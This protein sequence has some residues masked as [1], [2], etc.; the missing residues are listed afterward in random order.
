MMK[1]PFWMVIPS[2]AFETLAFMNGFIHIHPFIRLCLH[3]TRSQLLKCGVI[4]LQVLSPEEFEFLLSSD[5]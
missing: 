2:L 3:S 5:V 1:L 4:L